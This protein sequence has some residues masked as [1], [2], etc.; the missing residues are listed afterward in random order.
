MC[1][2]VYGSEYYEN[3]NLARE[4]VA[5]FA[6]SI[7]QESPFGCKI[8]IPSSSHSL[9]SLPLSKKHILPAELAVPLQLQNCT[10]EKGG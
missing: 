3:L 2:W 5:H 10:G 7:S 4:A 1:G 8:P 6:G 9:S